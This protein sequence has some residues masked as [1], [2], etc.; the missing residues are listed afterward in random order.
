MSSK[1]AS[2]VTL[3]DG[4]V[5][6]VTFISFSDEH[7]SK[8][9]SFMLDVLCPLITESDSVSY[10]LLDLIF[11]NIVEP[12]RTQR[13]NAYHLAKDLI[14][15]TSDT[16]ESYTQAFFNQIL[17]LDKYEKQYQIMSKIYDV[18]YELNV[19]SPSI[20]LSVL[21]Q[22]ECK[23]KSAQENERLKAVSLL[24]RMFSEKDST[25]AKQ[26]GPL[27]RQF[28][29]RFYDIA[30]PIR[31]KCVQSTMHFLLNHPHL[32]KDIIDILKV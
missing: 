12:L 29:G 30:V 19:I 4:T 10:D 8:V 6:K 3:L 14:V 9:K 32:R 22:L 18:I 31:I 21:P 27:W 2:D 23:L 15:K 28:L 16:L 25:L 13:K 11:I 24:A 26:Y 5:I 1:I 20:L 17:I 7:S